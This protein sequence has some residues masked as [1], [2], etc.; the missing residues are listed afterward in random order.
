MSTGGTGGKDNLIRWGYAVSGF[1]AGLGVAF[2]VFTE[3]LL[4]WRTNALTKQLGEIP[5]LRE[6]VQTRDK[7]VKSLTEEQAQIKIKLVELE[8]FNIFPLG[9]PYPWGLDKVKI[10]DSVDRLKEAYSGNDG[11]VGMSDTWGQVI[12]YR[13]LFSAAMYYF[14]TSR[15]RRIVAIRFSTNGI[16]DP[17]KKGTFLWEKLTQSLGRQ[18]PS[19]SE[20]KY[21]V[22]DAGKHLECLLI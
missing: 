11:E 18:I 8:A 4:P 14:D 12:L 2:F 20:G 1:M 5:E 22:W 6:K 21:R 17:G 19:K 13:G 9:S 16:Y 10:G 15:E 3:V 7:M